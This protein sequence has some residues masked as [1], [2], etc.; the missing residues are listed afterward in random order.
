MVI[1]RLANRILFLVGLTAICG[2][3]NAACSSGQETGEDAGGDVREN[4]SAS[5]TGPDLAGRDAAGGSDGAF[6]GSDA[7][8][9]TC[10]HAKLLWS[11]DFEGGDYAR[12]TSNTY[13]ASWGNECQSNGFSTDHPLSPTHSHRSQITCAYTAEGDVHRGYGGLQFSGDTV[14]PAYTNAGVGIDA[15]FGVVNT[16]HSWIDS[17]TVFQN[18]TWFSFWTV[19]SDCGW[20]DDVL[21]LGL[22][23]PSDRLAAAHYQPGG[24]SRTFLAGAPGFPRGR[25]VRIT[26]YVNYYDG[27]MHVWQDGQ[28][29]SHVLFVR[30]KSTICQWHW[31]AYASGDN[32]NLVLYEDDNSIWKLEQ[33]WTDF[34]IEPWFDKTVPVCTP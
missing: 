22:E 31:G 6:D 15:P 34:S 2:G 14:V 24:G 8:A 17:P 33:A 9:G 12:W 21:T 30:P 23:D 10:F 18:G 25:W 20:A 29:S 26:I 32:D 28:P 11:E 7:A 27:V 16:F 19:N 4:T 1:L 3:L 5:E 13:N